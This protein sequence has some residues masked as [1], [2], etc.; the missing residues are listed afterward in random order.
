MQQKL[1]TGP[2]MRNSN[3]PFAVAG[4]VMLVVETDPDTNEDHVV[5]NRLYDGGGGLFGVGEQLT[6]IRN[7]RRV[8]VID[9]QL[10]D[11]ECASTALDM[12]GILRLKSY[13]EYTSDQIPAVNSCWAIHWAINPELGVLRSIFNF[14][15]SN[16]ASTSIRVESSWAPARVWTMKT[17]RSVDFV[18]PTVDKNSDT[19]SEAM[20]T[21]SYMVVPGFLD[22]NTVDCDD[23]ANTVEWRHSTNRG[24]GIP[25]LYFIYYS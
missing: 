19:S 10:T 20:Y 1:A 12:G 7:Q 18:Q 21:T 5:V 23:D 22:A 8:P 13:F 2:V 24:F 6:L 16:V 4:D 17:M 15:H 11:S 14:C 25:E 9:C 3:Q